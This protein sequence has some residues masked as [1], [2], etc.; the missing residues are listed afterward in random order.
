[1]WQQETEESI[2]S[3]SENVMGPVDLLIIKQKFC[4]KEGKKCIL[5]AAL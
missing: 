1:M 4:F 2:L 3:E 5:I